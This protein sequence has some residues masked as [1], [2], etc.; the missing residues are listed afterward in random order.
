MQA[1]N[2]LRQ[3]QPKAMSRARPSL[4]RA[5][6]ALEDVRQIVFADSN[7]EILLMEVPMEF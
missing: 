1:S 6:K 4:V 5:V 2:A 7:A 3:R